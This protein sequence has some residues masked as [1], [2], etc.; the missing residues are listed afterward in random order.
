L[1]SGVKS[2]SLAQSERDSF[3]LNLAKK[4]GI[5]GERFTKDDMRRISKDNMKSIKN[6][7][8]NLELSIQ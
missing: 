7:Q 4:S 6:G 3:L 5:Q 2:H 1:K 8:T